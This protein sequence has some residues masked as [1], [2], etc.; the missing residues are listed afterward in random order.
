MISKYFENKNVPVYRWALLLAC[1]LYILWLIF[2]YRYHFIDNVNLV[3]HEAG[4][5]F[6]TP[7]GRTMHFIGG[8]I[9][10]LIFPVVV[11]VYFWREK[12]YFEAGVG[13]IWL[14]ESCL[15]TGEYMGDA[16]D[17]LLPLVGGG[18]HDWHFLFSQWGVLDSTNTFSSFVY[19]LG[20]VILLF[21][22]SIMYRNKKIETDASIDNLIK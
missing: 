22:F 20:G 21:G 2:F 13:L 9:G 6:F 10:Q 8:T 18:I 19:L 12:K 16:V 3:F 11:A 17:Q 15:Y 7:L 5:L 14:G 1:F 4:H